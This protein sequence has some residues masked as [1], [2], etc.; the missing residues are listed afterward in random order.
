MGFTSFRL[1]LRYI[2]HRRHSRSSHR[3]A[4]CR[5]FLRCRS[6]GI[7]GRPFCPL[8]GLIIQTAGPAIETIIPGCQSA[9][10]AQ[11]RA[12][13]GLIGGDDSRMDKKGVKHWG[14]LLSFGINYSI[15]LLMDLFNF[16]YRL[17]F[18][19]ADFLDT[20]RVKE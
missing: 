11:T 4:L 20:A 16:R 9:A 7:G 8:K 6:V 18:A 14:S 5:R 19:G 17:F 2:R 13:L 15:K 12:G 1:S 10:T 3:L